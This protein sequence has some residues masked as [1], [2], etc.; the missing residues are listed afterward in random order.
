M[1]VKRAP[2]NAGLPLAVSAC[3]NETTAST[4]EQDL[5]DLPNWP[6]ALTGRLPEAASQLGVTSPRRDA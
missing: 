1:L 2:E 6:K 4:E 3:A 5:P